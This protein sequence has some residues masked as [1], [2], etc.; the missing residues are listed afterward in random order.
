[1]PLLLWRRTRWIGVGLMLGFHLMNA[2][3]LPIGIF[4]WFMIAATLLFLDPA[5]FTRKPL[6]PPSENKIHWSLLA[7]L[8]VYCL[9][10]LFIPLRHFLYP[11]DV[12]W[13]EEGHR[14][15][16]HMR[17]RD[18]D[19]EQVVFIVKDV[20]TGTH[21]EVNP[22]DYLANHQIREMAAQPEMIYQF[23]QYLETLLDQ[24]TAESFQDVQIFACIRVSLNNRAAQYLINPDFNLLAQKPSA[25]RG[26]IPLGA[27]VD[28]EICG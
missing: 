15:A 3:L 17:L 12:S 13:T 10:Q 18:K 6:A 21:W 27:T 11:G 5:R 28:A 20:K 1:V 4:P 2:R 22:R 14:F 9:L 24:D 16:W 23:A 19:A 8:G 7:V 25:R 26:I